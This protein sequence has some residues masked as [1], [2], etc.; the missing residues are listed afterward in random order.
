MTPSIENTSPR[1]M[2]DCVIVACGYEQ[3]SR[4]MAE[5]IEFSAAR[6]VAYAYGL[7]EVLA[8]KANHRIFSRLNYDIQTVSDDEFYDRLD[9]EIASVRSEGGRRTLLVDI[10]CFTRFRLASLIR[11]FSA[12]DDVDVD[13]FYSLASYSPPSG[14][15]PVS[16]HVGP[17]SEYFSGWSG[18]YTSPAVVVSGL[19]Y[20]YMKALGVIELVD[21]SGTWLF[22]PRSPIE[23]YDESVDKAN[24]LLLRDVDSTQVIPYDVVNAPALVRDLF[25][26]LAHLRGHFRCVLIPLGPKIFAF[27]AMLAGAYFR[28]IAVWRVSAGKFSRPTNRRPS[29]VST[30]FRVSFRQMDLTRRLP[31]ADD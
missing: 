12:L 14:D 27:C 24:K 20:E 4:H 18:E 29:G 9:S 26:L 15:D 19:G 10:S 11:C 16:D 25:S 22:L 30:L 1:K 21:P 3:R 23:A 2:Y 6:R 13:F 28:D 5:S 31:A 8:F 7:H 17:A